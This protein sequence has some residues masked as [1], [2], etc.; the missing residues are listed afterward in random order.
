M[1]RYLKSFIFAAAVLCVG[2]FSASAQL[3]G[4]ERQPVTP[5]ATATPASSIAATAATS[6]QPTPM[7]EEAKATD[8][9]FEHLQKQQL[10]VI[11]D[12]IGSSVLW[13]DRSILEIADSPPPD[14]LGTFL[15]QI[16]AVDGSLAKWFGDT[17][18]KQLTT[19]HPARRNPH[20]S[21]ARTDEIDSNTDGTHCFVNPL[22]LTYILARYPKAAI[23]MRKSTD[24]VIFTVDGK[25]HAVLVPWTSLPDGTS[26]Q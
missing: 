4:N 3:P 19:W 5:A 11:K 14:P 23:L 26:L 13:T 16:P 20:P 22:Y 1:H 18:E 10:K 2:R 6:P 8:A 21:K 24:P 17:F 9:L 15:N 25:I 12:T 7:S